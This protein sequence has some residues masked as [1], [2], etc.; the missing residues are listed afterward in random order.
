MLLYTMIHMRAH[1]GETEKCGRVHVTV[2][3]IMGNFWWVGTLSN[4]NTIAIEKHA[5]SCCL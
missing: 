5:Y 1:V 2:L 4:T 3:S